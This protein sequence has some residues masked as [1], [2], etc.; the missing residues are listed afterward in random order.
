[1]L[2]QDEMFKSFEGDNYFQRRENSDWPDEERLAA[3][4]PLQLIKRNNLKITNAAEVGAYNGFRL[5]RIMRDYSCKAV[6]FEPSRRAVNNGKTQYPDIEFHCNTA[7]KL[8]AKDGAFDLVIA[9]YVF[10]WIDR[11]TLLRSV[12]EIDRVLADGGHLVISDFLVS[13]PER[14]RYHHLPEREVWTYKQKYEDIFI[15][16]NLYALVDSASKEPQGKDTV[17]RVCVLLKKSLHGNYP[18]TENTG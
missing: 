1:M 12:S 14:T 5:A 10:H 15:F 18:E 9:S 6:A 11:K 13:R 2:N 16:T 7:S 8:D 4:L 17:R 3:D